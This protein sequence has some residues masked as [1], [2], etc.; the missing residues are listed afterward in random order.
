M[1]RT[2]L[3]PVTAYAYARQH[4]Y[5]GTEEQ[6]EEDIANAALVYPA[7]DTLS[8]SGR[9]A[10]ANAVGNLKN[11]MFP[12]FDENTNYFAGD[13]VYHN[14]LLCRFNVD[15]SA[16][17]WNPLELYSIVAFNEIQ[18]I[19]ANLKTAI[20]SPAKINA[21][22][23]E[24]GSAQSSTAD[25]RPSTTR[26]RFSHFKIVNKGTSIKF[27]QG[28][29]I[30][31]YYYFVCDEDGNL[32]DTSYDFI[33]DS[34]IYLAFANKTGYLF[35]LFAAS[36]DS[37]ITPSQYDA[38]VEIVQNNV[39]ENIMEMESGELLSSAPDGDIYGLDLSKHLTHVR[40][41]YPFMLNGAKILVFEKATNTSV[42]LFA[43]SQGEYIRNV[44]L[45]TNE[46]TIVRVPSEA[47]YI[48][49]DIAS[50]E[51]FNIKVVSYGD[52]EPCFGKRIYTNSGNTIRLAFD[53]ERENDLFT[54]MSFKLPPNYD[55][56]GTKVPMFLWIAGTGGYNGILKG[57]QG[58][59]TQGGIEYIRDEGYAV[60]Q[61]FSMGSYY[62]NKY[63]QAANDQP[64]PIPIC[65]KA[66]KKG[67]EYFVDRY[68]IDA[69]NIH[70][71]SVSFGG[72][73]SF[74]YVMHPL[75]GMKSATL[76]DPCIDTLS[77][78][79]RFSESRKL[80]AEELKFQGSNVQ[81]FYDI[82]EDGTTRTGV[83][84]YYFSE[85]CQ[86]VWADNL[87]ALIRINPAW[88]RLIGGTHQENYQSSIADA[89]KWWSEGRHEAE[90]IYIHDEYKMI[91]ALPLKI[92]GSEDDDSTTHQIMLEKVEQLRNCGNPAEIY[93]V[94]YGGHG[95]TSYLIYTTWVQDITTALGISH[96]DVRIGWIEAVRWA[97]KNS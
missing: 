47:T 5:I 44:T 1:I 35:M 68:N 27:S 70:V 11:S 33:D 40:N 2:D 66:I 84:N 92:I 81:D 80:L 91:S 76:F 79:G 78:R 64:Y 4:G 48:D 57:F 63:P 21:T 95:A 60:L 36:D 46:D 13:Y 61:V 26:L 39:Y 52:E 58:G 51:K 9:A 30:K 72:I 18:R 97:R 71:L 6:F 86:S 32:I 25:K 83:E 53:I 67:I 90:N 31:K 96:A 16:G 73:M 69:D 89:R 24:Q 23:I 22:E 93:L 85:R 55:A 50:Q 62:W 56:N 14:G 45:R 77:M 7:D 19:V 43:N 38:T 29:V 75:P 59:P 49:I 74:H 94:P 8:V 15:H 88:D 28:N 34:E 3:G 65:E 54:F 87:P 10:D 41:K 82:E 20:A 37:T 12:P 17:A 42:L